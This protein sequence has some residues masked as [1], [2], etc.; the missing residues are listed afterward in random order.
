MNSIRKTII[1]MVICILLT[2]CGKT[3]EDIINVHIEV[4]SVDE[5]NILKIELHEQD[6]KNLKEIFEESEIYTDNGVVFAEGGYRFVI[7]TEK[8]RINLYSYCGGTAWYKV[9]EEGNIYLNLN[10]EEE[11]VVGNIL[12][13]YVKSCN[14]EGIW[15]WN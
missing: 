15:D 9:G 12:K 7:E 11:K 10:S 2:G 1:L 5:K 4:L 13:R 3:I 14:R 6:V 8:E